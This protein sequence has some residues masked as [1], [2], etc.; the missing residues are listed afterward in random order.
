MKSNMYKM[1]ATLCICTFVFAADD[2]PAWE[3]NE[4][5]KSRIQTIYRS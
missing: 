5:V 2:V 1:M 4:Y 3:K